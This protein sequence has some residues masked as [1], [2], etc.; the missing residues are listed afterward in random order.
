MLPTLSVLSGRFGSSDASSV[1][2]RC[3][4]GLLIA[5]HAIALVLMSQTEVGLV[6]KAAFLLVWAGL[7]LAAAVLWR[8][9]IPAAISSLAL[10]GTLILLSQ[11]KHEKLW[12]T[13]DFVD[14]MIIDRDTTAF[15]L[16]ALPKLRLP[17]ATG[18]IV[19]S[20]LLI[21]ASRFDPLRIRR[22]IALAGS[23]C[24]LG[25]LVALS[26]SFPTNLA[27]DFSGQNYVSKFARTGVEAVDA[28]IERGYLETDKTAPRTLNSAAAACNPSRKLPHIILLHD[29]SSF[30]IT[31]VPGIKVPHG[32]SDFFRSQDGKARKLVVEGAGGPSWFTEYNVLT[33]LSARS[34]GPFATSV[35]RMAAGHVKR[36][37]PLSLRRCGYKTYSLYPFYGAF[38][39]SRAFQTTA[40]VGNYLDMRD[41]GTR[42]FETD[43]FYFDQARKIIA[44]QATNGPLFLY[45]YNVANHFPWDTRLRPNLTPDWRDPGNGS[46][47]DEYIRRQSMTAHDYHA[48]LA[49]LAADFPHESFLIVR[50]GDHLP[51]LALRLMDPSLD[52]P[53]IAQRLEAS[54]PRYLTTYYAIDTVNFEP[55]DLSSALDTVDAPYLPLIIQEAAGVPLGPSFQEQ[56]TILSRCRGIFYR[57]ANGREARQFNRMLI[58]AGYIT[59]L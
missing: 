19:L 32:Y 1:R 33:G 51:S 23:M 20:G 59:G 41:L 10:L 27:E 54:D 28:L 40:G 26:M 43:S 7:N 52:E 2:V 46:Q 13:V 34:Y 15:L 45:V 36:G 9:P 29:E 53:A 49:Q 14:L 48:F 12:L 16:Q 22:R 31:A 42:N 58:Q 11:F 56:K 50:Y 18:V 17:A 4:I 21:A 8:R 57:C 35:T 25:A 38:L 47:V 5:L 24:C 44:K 30:D 3:A 6:G 37:L 39:G 55:A